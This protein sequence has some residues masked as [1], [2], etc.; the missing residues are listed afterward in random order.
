MNDVSFL[1][2][3]VTDGFMHVQR[4]HLNTDIRQNPLNCSDSTPFQLSTPFT[5]CFPQFIQTLLD[6]YEDYVK[7]GASLSHSK[8]Y[9][10]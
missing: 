2:V 6:C 4:L 8:Q 7:N 5:V 9:L 3:S 10:N 1:T